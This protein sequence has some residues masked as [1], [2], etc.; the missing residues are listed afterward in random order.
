MKKKQK[1]EL[2]AAVEAEIPIGVVVVPEE[3]G[4]EERLKKRVDFYID[5]FKTMTE[6]EFRDIESYDE[7]RTRTP[8]D[9]TAIIDALVEREHDYGTCV[10]AMTHA[11][12]AAYNY[13]AYKLG[14]TGFQASCA[15]LAFI[16]RN[17][18][19][20]DGFR[21]LDYNKLLYPQYFNNPEHFPTAHQLLMDNQEALSKKATELLAER[22]H[23]HPDV[24]RHWEWIQSLESK[25]KSDENV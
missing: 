2:E 15:D 18:H 12:L 13:V 17:R 16:R 11:A 19:Y 9:L 3:D 20:E 8:E 1:E 24:K 23:V 14:V 7:P 10:Y 25:A 4:R 21:I 22:E 6:K 5:S